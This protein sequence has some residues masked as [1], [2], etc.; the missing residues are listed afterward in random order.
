MLIARVM[1]ISVASSLS[2]LGQSNSCPLQP[3]G[4]KNV[5][6]RIA[7]TMQNNSGKKLATYTVGLQ[8]FDVNGHAYAFPQELTDTVK[9]KQHGKRTAIWSA[10]SAHQFLFPLV[11]AYTTKAIFT[12]GTE[13]NDDGSKSCS[14]TSLQE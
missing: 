4:V 2:A 9:L 6:S 1:L 10:P 5:A 13:W 3:I 12:D 14:V 11:K 8:F 7:V